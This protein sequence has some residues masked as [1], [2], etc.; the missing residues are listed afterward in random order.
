MN[1]TPHLTTDP[2]ID[3]AADPNPD[4]TPGPTAED[5]LTAQAAAT[6]T[7]AD[8]SSAWTE[9]GSPIGPLRLVA[10]GA[11]LRAVE[12]SPYPPTTVEAVGERRD[13]LPVLRRA[14]EQL[15]AYFSGDLEAFDLPL[16]PGGTAF[17]Q[18][19]WAELSRI[20]YGTTTS[21][22]EVA[23]RL[24]MTAAASRAVGLA[25]GRNPIPVVVPCHRVVGA[26][27][28]LTGYAGGLERKQVLLDLE[29]PGLF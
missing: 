11:S 4:P 14:A 19:V 8:A 18:R 28:R 9:V 7:Q 2:V 6:P 25:N 16:D 12:F 20:D 1:P 10:R 22:G 26:D 29:R 24:G 17:Q 13:D 5:A 27:G 21:Y 23:R 3:P 15:A